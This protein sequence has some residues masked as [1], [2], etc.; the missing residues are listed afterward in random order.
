MRFQ[1]GA[2]PISPFITVSIRNNVNQNK[3]CYKYYNFQI[4]NN[5]FKFVFSAFSSI[6]GSSSSSSGGDHKKEKLQYPK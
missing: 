3:I 2:K 5:V 6:L 4:K 1:D